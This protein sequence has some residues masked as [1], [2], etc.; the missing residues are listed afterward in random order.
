M[1]RRILEGND[2]VQNT[3]AS[4]RRQPDFMAIVLQSFTMFATNL[5]MKYRV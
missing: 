4:R 3:H 2:S 5:V 1:L